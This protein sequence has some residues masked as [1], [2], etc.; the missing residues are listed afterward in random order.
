MK[1]LF[2][3][4]MEGLGDA[5]YQRPFVRAQGELRPTYIDSV[6][7]EIYTDLRGVHLV[8]PKP[9][10]RTQAQNIR[11]LVGFPF[12]ESPVEFGGG[13]AQRNRDFDQVQM[14]YSLQR[15]GTICQE[16]ERHVGLG[17]RSFVFDA[18]DFG[19]PPVEPPYAVVRPASVRREWIN[20]ARNPDP[21]YIPRA[22]HLLRTAGYKV[23]VVADLKPGVETVE[24][25]MPE[26]DTYYTSGELA[27][28]AL[29]ALLKHASV[30]VGPV[31][32]IVPVCLAYRTPAVIV[33]GGLGAHNAPETITDPRID[34]SRMRFL[35]PQPYCRRCRNPRHACRK[36]I[37]DFDRR[38]VRAL[39]ELTARKAVA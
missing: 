5:I 6:W 14:T 20:T 16:L 29:F 2:I 4:M 31:G 7:P 36:A 30:V 33:C 15:P 22:S 25:D 23:V 10:Y 24:G 17:G 9:K 39:A 3:R 21:A 12:E 38:F 13:W 27:Q 19:V 35:L 32:F 28:P 37:P 11:R 1:P 8:R 26:G 18:P 34:S